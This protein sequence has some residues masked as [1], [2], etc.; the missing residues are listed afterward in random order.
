[1]TSL[2]VLHFAFS[3]TFLCFVTLLVS[4][5]LQIAELILIEVF[6]TYDIPID[7]SGFC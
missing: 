3:C 1:M 2:F 5:K 7:V 6:L 4:K